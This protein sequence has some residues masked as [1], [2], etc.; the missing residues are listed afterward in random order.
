MAEVLEP[1]TFSREI[2]GSMSD[3]I[4]PE[5]F[6]KDF[7]FISDTEITIIMQIVGP[8]I[9]KAVN[10]FKGAT[11]NKFIIKTTRNDGKQISDQFTL[12]DMESGEGPDLGVDID[13]ESPKVKLILE[14]EK[15]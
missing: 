9:E 13:I 5:K 11:G 7:S 10:F 12:I 4:V 6:I 2:E 14:F 3:L 1:V 15:E 8:D